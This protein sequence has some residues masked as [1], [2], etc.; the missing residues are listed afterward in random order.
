[1]RISV[2]AALLWL[3]PTLLPAGAAAQEWTE[4]HVIQIFREQSPYAREARARAAAAGAEALERTL[5]PNP[6]VQ[7]SREGAGLTEFYQAEQSLPLNGRRPLLRA[8]GEMAV[9][10]VRSDAASDTWQAL[11]GLRTAFYRALAAQ[12]REAV[13]S[14][15]LAEI[16]RVLGVLRNREREGEGSRFDRLR[17]E[18]ERA[19]LE[20]DLALA[21]AE[22]VFE[23]GRLMAYLPGAAVPRVTGSLDPLPGHLNAAELATRA[24]GARADI[25]AEQ[26]RVNQFR[27]EERA[28]G[29]RRVP[30]PVV[31]AG[32]KRADIGAGRVV[33]GT[34]VGLALNIPLFN[35]GQAEQA[36]FA[37]EQERTNARLEILT[38]RVR[39]EVESAAN[40]YNARVEARAAYER[41]L[42]GTGPELIRIATIAY[43]EGEI[44]ILQLLDAYRTRRDAQLRSLA[45]RTAIKEAQIELERAIGEE[46]GR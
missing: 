13:H 39:A 23:R 44:S 28:A 46:I 20:T 38:Q 24:L 32:Y 8:A 3:S 2:R 10:A 5:L 22:G 34:V 40:A 18:R 30:D 29:R 16:D 4:A 19:D 42:T 37:A 11:G 12:E 1:M 21:R 7:V 26:R 36:R 45:L 6:S 14:G 41:A 27:L 25:R 17:A 43:Q 31:T 15:A 35:Q 9:E 33:N